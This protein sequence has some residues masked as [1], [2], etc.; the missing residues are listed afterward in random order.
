MRSRAERTYY[1]IR[2]LAKMLRVDA[3]TVRNWIK[4]GDLVAIRLG[5][6]YRIAAEDLDEFL[7]QRRTNKEKGTEVE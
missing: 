7:S 4:R 2:E 1:T 5:K 6:R 3:R